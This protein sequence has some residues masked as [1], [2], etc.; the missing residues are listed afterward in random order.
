MTLHVTGTYGT[1]FSTA[2]NRNILGLEFLHLEIGT[3]HPEATLNQFI[4]DPFLADAFNP[5]AADVLQSHSTVNSATPLSFDLDA[6]VSYTKLVQVGDVFDIG[7]NVDADIQTGQMD[8]T[9]TGTVSF[10]LPEGVFL[11]SALGAHFDEAATSAVPEPSALALALCGVI[12]AAAG[13]RRR[14]MR[15]L[16]RIA[17]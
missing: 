13:R 14:L 8:L 7:Y 5:Q 12:S 6:Q 15:P 3:F 2:L 16:G 10:T 11:D 9:H 1:I 17:V 4:V